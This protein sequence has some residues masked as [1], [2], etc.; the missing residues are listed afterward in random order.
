MPLRRLSR[1]RPPACGIYGCQTRAT[2]ECGVC[3][4]QLCQDCLK[5]HAKAHAK[6][7]IARG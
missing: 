6:R 7:V 4:R 1:A 3:H 2:H 5:G